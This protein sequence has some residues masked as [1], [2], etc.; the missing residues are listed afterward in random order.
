MYS[1]ASSGLS[2]R[3][4]Y[5]KPMKWLIFDWKTLKKQWYLHNV[6]IHSDAWPWWGFGIDFL[7]IF[8]LRNNQFW[9][10]ILT[11][12]SNR[13]PYW[14]LF[15]KWS[16]LRLESDEAVGLISLA[17]SLQEMITSDAR[18]WWGFGLISLLD[19]L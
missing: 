14:I 2:V 7:I 13:F 15:K 18:A 9:V 12:L 10:L 19:S 8:S 6:L 1:K 17:D 11:R 4:D 3:I 5:S 16:I